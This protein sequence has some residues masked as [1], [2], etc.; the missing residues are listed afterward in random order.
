MQLV[1]EIED[2]QK[3]LT[4]VMERINVN[5]KVPRPPYFPLKRLKDFIDVDQINDEQFSDLVAYYKSLGGV[6]L[7]EAVT[8]SLNESMTE[9]VISHLTWLGDRYGTEALNVSKITSAIYEAMKGNNHFDPPTKS[10]FKIAMVAALKD[11][12]YG[13]TAGKARGNVTQRDPWDDDE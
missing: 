10:E 5:Q 6:T 13:R 4:Q 7:E 8:I 3:T 12:W 2:N 1:R 11:I 9:Y